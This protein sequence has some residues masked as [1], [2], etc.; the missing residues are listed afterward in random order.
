MASRSSPP[1]SH[2]VTY[3]VRKPRIAAKSTAALSTRFQSSRIFNEM[4][5]L[6]S[7]HPALSAWSRNVTNFQKQIH[8]LV[9]GSI[10][11]ALTAEAK[12]KLGLSPS[13]VIYDELGSADGRALFDAMDSALGAREVPAHARDLDPGCG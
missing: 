3:A 1:P 12:T 11:V 8:D 2:S 5:A 9:N 7:R 10:Y 4:V 13:F 6:I